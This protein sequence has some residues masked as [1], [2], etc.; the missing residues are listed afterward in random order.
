MYQQYLFNYLNHL[1]QSYFLSFFSLSNF[2]QNPSNLLVFDLSYIYLREE[3]EFH[4][5]KSH[6]WK[7]V[8]RIIVSYFLRYLNFS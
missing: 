4:F 8:F 7:L 2:L 6:F 3:E 1:K 5:L